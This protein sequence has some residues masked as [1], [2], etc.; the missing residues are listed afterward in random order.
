MNL[1]SDLSRLLAQGRLALFLGVDLA[2]GLA[3]RKGLD[4]ALSLAA[5]AQR[6]ARAR[7]SPTLRNVLDTTGKPPQPFQQA[8]VGFNRAVRNSDVAFVNLDRPTLI[9]LY[10]NAQQPDTLVVTEET[11]TAQ[12]QSQLRSQP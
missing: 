9:K 12:A 1:V 7:N 4:E 3:R 10:G 11:T 8:G 2:R 6:V 5:I